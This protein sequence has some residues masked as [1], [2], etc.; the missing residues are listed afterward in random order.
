MFDLLQWLNANPELAGVATFAVA[1]AESI[2]IVGTIIPGTVTM[3]A[4]GTLAGAGVIPLYAT[5]C[6]AILG[7]IVGDGISYWMGRYFNTRLPTLWPFRAHPNLLASGET[8]FY[9]HGSMSVFIGRFVGPV[10]A[11]VPL[12]A[13]MLRMSPVR[14]TIANILSAIGWAPAYMLPGILL[15]AA[16][17][18]LPPDVAVHVILTL[19]LMGLLILFCLWLVQKLF[20]LIGHRINQSL[21]SLWQQLGNSRYFRII[22]KTLKHHNTKKTYGQLT[23]TFYFLVT[24]GLICYLTAYI[25]A[26]GSKNIAINNV[27]FHLFRSFRTPLGDTIMLAVAFLGEKYVLLP[28]AVTL[29]AWLAWTKRW[30]T[31]WHVLA[32]G[33]ITA[34]GIATMKL[35]THSARP[36]GVMHNPEEFSFPSGHTTL[37]VAFY[38]GI[39]LLL[40]KSLKLKSWRRNLVF[41]SATLL[42]LAISISRLYLGLHWFTDMLGGWLLGSAVL[43][44]IALSYNRKSEKD[45]HPA[46]IILTIVLTLATTYSVTVYRLFTPLKQNYTQIDWPTYAITLN[47]WW[48]WQGGHLPI[49]R[50]NRFGL[51]EQILNLQWI[52]NL[53]TIK[54]TLLQ[55]G[56]QEAPT[57]DWI[58]ALHR[59][60][61]VGS[62][63]HLPLVS[64]LY[65]DKHPVLVLV[66][67]INGDKK[68]IVLRLWDPNLIIQKIKQPLWVGTVEIIPRTYSWLFKRRWQNSIKLT[69]DLVFSRPQKEYDIKTVTVQVTHTNGARSQPIILI[70]PKNDQV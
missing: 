34:G 24:C 55:N 12:V 54:K 64:P 31:A 47:S 25:Y 37:A 51:S 45:L 5:V 53:D 2:A 42:I 61:D 16:S 40:V 3:T 10:R 15:G 44:L 36:W 4:I 23:L 48:N 32:L 22:T 52:D 19:L 43:M 28:L 65:L 35:F 33:I 30:H 9:K 29:F 39:A 21:T 60:T 8:F 17:L 7:A 38:V 11:L 63:E 68:I 49:Y 70:K 66:K 26:V 13:G 56:W 58:S 6:W 27:F 46:G 14:F 41:T 20:K 57:R 18:E 50:I 1:A 62:A 67:R 59:I 69:Q